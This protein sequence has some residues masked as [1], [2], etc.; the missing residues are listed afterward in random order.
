MRN[1]ILVLGSFLILFFIYAFNLFRHPGNFPRPA[2]KERNIIACGPSINNKTYA[3][4]IPFFS[5]WSYLTPF[6]KS[7]SYLTPS[8]L[9][10]PG[11]T[12]EISVNDNRKSA[13]ELRNGILYI[14]LETRNGNWFPETHEGEGMQVFAFAEV[15]KPMQLPGPLI[16]VSE[17]T[18]IN[19]EIHHRIPGLPLI[20]HGLYT[21]PGNTNDSVFIPYDSRQAGPVHIS[22]GLPSI[23]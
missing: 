2:Y 3:G 23:H 11:I 7:W 21:R 16:R 22:I 8:S 13:G 17:G 10:W 6:A 4:I 19:A 20:L 12:D 1:V 5:S 14:K 15:G 18:I 9:S